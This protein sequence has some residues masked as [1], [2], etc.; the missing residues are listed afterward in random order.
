MSQQAPAPQ[1]SSPRSASLE[2][3]LQNTAAVST[4]A[5]PR[6]VQAYGIRLP[7]SGSFA[8]PTFRPALTLRGASPLAHPSAEAATP[9]TPAVVNTNASLQ[10][11]ATAEDSIAASPLA[12]QQAA[13]PQ[14][15][16]NRA[17]PQDMLLQSIRNNL[18][19][20]GRQQ[21]WLPP[22]QGSTSDLVREIEAHF[23]HAQQLLVKH[24]S[25]MA[26]A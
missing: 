17:G 25:I 3:M 11:Q 24:R 4:A 7:A 2:H 20:A 15:H 5:S 18:P 21:A 1:L 19:A 13:T 10:S 9:P 16:I 22:F 14:G 6:A 23:Q 12:P 8:W 26:P